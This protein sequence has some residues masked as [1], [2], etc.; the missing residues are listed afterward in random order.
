MHCIKFMMT[1]SNGNIFRVNSLF[2]RRR[3]PF[4]EASDV[5]LLYDLHLNKRL[6]KQS[7][8]QWSK[9]PLRSLWRRYCN[10][11]ANSKGK[12]LYSLVLFCFEW[13]SYV[14]QTCLVFFFKFIFFFQIQII[15][16]EFSDQPR[17]DCVASDTLFQAPQSTHSGGICS[18]WYLFVGWSLNSRK[19]IWIW[20]KKKMKINS[21]VELM[22]RGSQAMG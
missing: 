7:R 18:E 8:R 13:N 10:V 11:W 12:R 20:K 5:E 22:I 2:G 1:W 6:S 16:L 19:K 4:T 9:T 14:F 21:F 3:I 15:F 17:I